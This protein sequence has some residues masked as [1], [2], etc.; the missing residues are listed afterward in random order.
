MARTDKQSR[1]LHPWLRMVQNGTRGVNALRADASTR[2]ACTTPV[3]VDGLEPGGHL[4]VNVLKV[5]HHGSE[6]NLDEDFAA[7][8]SANH[9]V[10]CGNGE[11]GNPDLSV[12]DIVFN[13]R[14]DDHDAF[15]FWF[16]T[17]SKAQAGQPN[18]A[19]FRQVEK[20]AR[21]LRKSSAGRLTLHVN[22]EA[23]IVLP[24]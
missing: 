17:T 13:S 11:H 18:Q 5:Q 21:A 16:G 8:V 3:G 1:K 2:V 7:R 20:R 19:H 23:A 15:E 9:Y 4:R 14:A 12:L 22:E 24:I 6:N 10:F